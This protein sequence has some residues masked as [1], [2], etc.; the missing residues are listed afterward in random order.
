MGGVEPRAE[1]GERRAGR[2]LCGDDAGLI[3]RL[4]FLAFRLDDGGGARHGLGQR[5]R[6]AVSG[7]VEMVDDAAA[8]MRPRHDLVDDEP[9]V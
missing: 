4:A 7:G 2:R 8:Q 1:G 5:S 9:A 3:A 6:I